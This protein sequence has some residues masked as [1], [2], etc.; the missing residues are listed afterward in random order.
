M[1]LKHAIGRIKAAAALLAVVS[2]VAAA[3]LRAQSHA[4]PSAD[5]PVAETDS[6]AVATLAAWADQVWLSLLDRDGAYYGR[7]AEEG[8]F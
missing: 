3:S 6:A 2:L 8:I 4:E 1:T 7:L 5:S